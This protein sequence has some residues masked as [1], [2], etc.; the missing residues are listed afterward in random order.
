MFLSWPDLH[1]SLF[2]SSIS[3]LT[4][5]GCGSPA[6]FRY[7]GGGEVL[8]DGG[9]MDGGEDSGDLPSRSPG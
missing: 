8:R 1:G 2:H 3:H 9:L 4:S 7:H 5:D 6:F